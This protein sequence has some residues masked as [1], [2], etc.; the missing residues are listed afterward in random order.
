[1]S[2]LPTIDGPHRS[3]RRPGRA[4]GLGGALIAA[5]AGPLAAAP[6]GTDAAGSPEPV[7]ITLGADAFATASRM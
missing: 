2:E 7:W 5:L 3:R 6:T 4:L 1:M